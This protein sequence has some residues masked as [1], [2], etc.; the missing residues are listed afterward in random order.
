[1]GLAWAH[2]PARHGQTVGRCDSLCRSPHVTSHI[3]KVLYTC[4]EI[5]RM[6]H[7]SKN[8]EHAQNGIDLQKCTARRRELGPEGIFLMWRQKRKNTNDVSKWSGSPVVLGAD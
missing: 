2:S 8:P 1:M 3:K 6:E 7:P 5:N 4:P